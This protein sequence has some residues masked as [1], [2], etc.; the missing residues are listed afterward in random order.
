[1]LNVTEWNPAV[2]SFYTCYGKRVTVPTKLIVYRKAPW[3]KGGPCQSRHCGVTPSRCVSPSGAPKS[4]EL[5]P[6]PELAVGDSHT[7]V[8]RVSGAAPIQNLT[9]ILRRDS[10]VLLAQTFE[11]ERWAEPVEVTHRLTARRQDNG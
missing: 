9:V 7:L 5:E 1:L 10:E 3:R 4:V 2:F 6:V 11:W 8:C